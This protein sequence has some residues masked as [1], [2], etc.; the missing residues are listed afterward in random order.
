MKRGRVIGEV[1]AT[2]KHPGIEGRKLLLVAA[3]EA[4]EGGSAPTGEVLV[5]MDTLDAAPGQ[6]V[7]V[8]WGSGARNAVSAAHADTVLSDAAVSVVLAEVFEVQ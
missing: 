5:A 2:R 1:W 6:E 8:S 7:L 4:R 3:T